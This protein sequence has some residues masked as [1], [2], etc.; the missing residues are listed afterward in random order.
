MATVTYLAPTVERRFIEH[1]AHPPPTSPRA[2]TCRM[3]HHPA[4][5][6]TAP[7]PGAV[8]GEAMREITIRTGIPGYSDIR[9]HY[10]FDFP[11]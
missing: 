11:A 8:D 10:R 4:R 1:V 6:S 7:S 9:E 2:T 5:V 3:T